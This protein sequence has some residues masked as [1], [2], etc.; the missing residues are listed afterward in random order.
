MKKSEICQ[1]QESKGKTWLRHLYIYIFINVLYMILYTIYVVYLSLSKFQFFIVWFVCV[2]LLCS[3]LEGQSPRIGNHY[4]CHGSAMAWR[5][6]MVSPLPW[7]GWYVFGVEYSFSFPSFPKMHRFQ[8]WE[9]INICRSSPLVHYFYLFLVYSV[10]SKCLSESFLRCHAA[11]ESQHRRLRGVVSSNI[12]QTP[13]SSR[14][15]Q[16]FWSSL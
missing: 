10:I 11:K 3:N 15:A 7:Y 6:S 2:L 4:I 13:G 12:H 8:D 1:C 9:S 5:T 16:P 14:L